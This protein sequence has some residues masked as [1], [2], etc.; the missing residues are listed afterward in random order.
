MDERFIS[1]QKKSSSQVYLIFHYL[2][3]RPSDLKKGEREKCQGPSILQPLC[4][5]LFRSEKQK[6]KSR[7]GN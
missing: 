4:E 3:Q 6:D 7:D 2:P 5:K 1:G